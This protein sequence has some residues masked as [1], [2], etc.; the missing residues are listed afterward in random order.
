MKNQ[1]KILA[2]LL[3]IIAGVPLCAQP[4]IVT[5]TIVDENKEPVSERLLH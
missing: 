2:F 4:I 1:V 3:S 5:G